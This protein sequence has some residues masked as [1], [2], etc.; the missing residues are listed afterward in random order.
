MT[1][2]NNFNRN[3]H[4]IVTQDSEGGMCGETVVAKFLIREDAEN[5]KRVM[6]AE[7]PTMYWNVERTEE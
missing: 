1:K 3:A 6:E 2:L 5:Y 7:W 4:W